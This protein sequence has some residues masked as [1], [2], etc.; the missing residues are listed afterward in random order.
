M[1]ATVPRR[2]ANP[3]VRRILRSQ[4]RFHYPEVVAVSFGPD[5]VEVELAGGAA[6]TPEAVTSL[7]HRV[8][9]SFARLP[10]IPVRVRYDS[11]APAASTPSPTCHDVPA[12]RSAARMLVAELTEDLAL[13]PPHAPV[14]PCRRA[15]RGLNLYGHE[16]AAL[17]RGLDQFLR[18]YFQRAYGAQELRA[19][20]MIPTSLAERVGYVASSRHHLS[21]VCPLETTPE[22]F[23]EFLPYWREA[24]AD[25][26]SPDGKIHRFLQVP[27]DVLNPAMCL[28]CYPL[29]ESAEVVPGQPAVLTLAGSC[30]RDESGNLNQEDRLREFAMREAVF[31]GD[32]ASLEAIHTEL[33]GFVIDVATLLGLD[34]RIEIATDIFFSDGSPE[35]I[36]SQLLSDNK[37]ELAVLAP[38][39]GESMAAASIN[40]HQAHFTIPFGIRTRDGRPA[41]SMCVAFGLDR[42]ALAVSRANSAGPGGLLAA[43][44]DAV[45]A[46]VGAGPSSGAGG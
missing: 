16:V 32:V 36:F 45:A 3:T 40:K 22:R 39:T 33:T 34:F 10:S 12:F 23:D 28:H 20:S 38:G 31:I 9:E 29:F 1:R 37:L 7:V 18:R 30:F 17:Q 46:R 26:G 11:S 24:I 5:T 41:F 6:V 2:V 27:E 13:A 8:A 25:G 15:G 35:R 42:L 21:F 14:G 43:V 19:P 4:L 44:R